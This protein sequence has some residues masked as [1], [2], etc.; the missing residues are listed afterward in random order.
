MLRQSAVWLAMAQVQEQQTYLRQ[1]L[2]NDS[3]TRRTRFPAPGGT[4]AATLPSD[5]VHKAK[6]AMLACL[7]PGE[8]QVAWIRDGSYAAAALA[9]LGLKDQS[10]AALQFYLSALGGRFQGW[11]E[12]KPYSMPPYQISLVRYYGFGVEETDFNDFGPNLEFDGFGLFL[13]ALRHYEKETKDPTLVDASWPTVSTKIADAL[14]SLIDPATGLMRPDSSIWESHWNGRQ[15]TWT[16]TNL[17]A[18]RGLCDASALAT[19]VGDMARAKTY[20]DAGLALRAAIATKLTDASGALASNAEELASGEGYWDAAVLDAIAMGL[21]DPKGRIAKATLAGL[22]AHLNVTAGAGWSRN[23]DRSDHAGKTDVSPWGSEYDSAE[24]IFTDLRGEVAKRLAGDTVRADR[25]LAWV[26]D[27]SLTNY[28]AVS[29]T[30]DEATGLYKFNAPMVGFGAGV[31]ALALA[32]RAA[33]LDEPACGAFYDEGTTPGDAGPDG[34]S[35][36]GT[37]DAGGDTSVPDASG[38]GGV[39]ATSDSSGVDAAGD[40]GAD[41]SVTLPSPTPDDGGCGC[42]TTSSAGSPGSTPTLLALALA[43]SIA[44]RRRRRR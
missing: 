38:D 40:A 33:P 32:N 12:L 36:T 42:R 30:Y 35:D 2:T 39:D 8:W 6:G 19:R 1:F 18:A 29:E 5:V 3:D 20:R 16:Y 37:G 7:P 21:F 11:N 10:K 22:D 13:W 14:V 9:S 17:T 43:G 27:Q 4:G 25:L 28:L 26:R 34:G 41:T 24:W 15:R 31:Y 44:A 23:D